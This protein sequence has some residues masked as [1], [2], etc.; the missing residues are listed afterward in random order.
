MSEQGKTPIQYFPT[1]FEVWNAEALS[2]MAFLH[3]KGVDVGCGR[4]SLHKQMVRVDINPEVE[5][6]HVAD[7]AQLPFGEGEFDFMWSSHN[8]EHTADAMQTILEAERVVKLGGF[9]VYII[10]DKNFTAGRD[11][12]HVCEWTPQEF[13]EKYAEIP[14]LQLVDFGR[15]AKQWS[16]KVVYQKV[17]S[18]GDTDAHGLTRTGGIGAEGRAEGS[19]MPTLS[20]RDG[21][22]T[23]RGERHEWSG[24]G[25]TR[26]VVEKGLESFKPRD[27]RREPIR[28]SSIS[29][30]P[31]LTTGF[32]LVH[33]QILAGLQRAL[34]RVS[35]LGTMDTTPPRPGEFPYYV[36]S[37]CKHDFFGYEAALPFLARSNPEVLF[38]LGDPGTLAQRM[39]SMFLLGARLPVVVYFPIEGT[40]IL[41]AYVSMIEAVQESGGRAVTYTAWGAQQIEE[42]S[43]GKLKV[44][45]VWHGVDHAPFR[46]YPEEERQRLR[47]LV[48]WGD[49]FV[50]MNVSRNKRT[51]RQAAYMQAARVLRDT[52]GV[53]DVLFYL[54]CDPQDQRAMDGMQGLDLKQQAKFYGVEEMVLFPPDLADQL[55]GPAYHQLKAT[56]LQSAVRPSTPEARAQMFATYSLIERYNCADLYVDASSVQGFNLPNVE[57][58]ACGLPVAATD[59]DGPRREVLGP[60]AMWMAPA[61]VDYW[62]T[63]ARLQIVTP[64]TIAATVLTM[65][66]DNLAAWSKRSQERALMF[67]WKACQDRFV[68]AI[69]EVAAE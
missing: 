19:L 29:D 63:G 56:G 11:P 67:R 41:S 61:A 45:W 2:V 51:N 40:P 60:A 66:K 15:A 3:G 27:M 46:R 23:L 16:F 13:M 52:Y 57:A 47:E 33:R 20:P 62:H 6:D 17:E 48:G 58:M 21:S 37:V 5:P 25:R 36:E 65:M 39:Q 1:E 9:L 10:P 69:K 59:D 64:E 34:F 7:A 49:K 22:S 8:L 28:V 68:Q 43:E 55:H 14:G 50:V 53:K 12:T 42:A 35:V 38:M 54:H 31:R 32:G 18:G 44:A 30:H 4:R 24:G 26:E